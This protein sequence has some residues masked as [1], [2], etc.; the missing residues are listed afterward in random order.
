MQLHTGWGLR[1]FSPGGTDHAGEETY[2]AIRRAILDGT[3][4]PGERIVEQQLAETLG[5]SRTPVR[6]ALLK[7]ERENLVARIGRGMAVRRYSSDEV[8]DI[9]SLRAHL[10]SFAARLAADRITEG[11]LAAL[12]RIQDEMEH[13]PLRPPGEAIRTL[14][15]HNQRFH[16]LVVRCARSAP[17]D[18]CF[19]QV[20]Q[21]PLLYKAYAY[22]DEERRQRSDR[23][24]REL[25]EMLRARRRR[26]R[27]GALAQPSAARRRRAR[28]APRRR[29]SRRV[30]SRPGRRLRRRAVPSRG[31]GPSALSL[32][33]PPRSRWRN[34]ASVIAQH[35]WQRPLGSWYAAV[36]KGRFGVGRVWGLPRW[37][38]VEPVTSGEERSSDL[39]AVEPAAAELAD[40][41]LQGIRVVEFGQLLAGPFVGTLLGDFG[42]EVI[43]IEAPPAGDPMREWGRLRHNGRSMWW[44]ILSR[45]KQSVTLNLRLEQGPAGRSDARPARRRGARELPPGDDGALGT[46]PRRASR[47]STRA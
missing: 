37:R 7:L 14:S 40:G 9:Y 22:F 10:E 46:G 8:R 36:Y 16:A 4:R 18:R 33:P 5:V 29:R 17:L 45:N 28:P 30:L 6:E 19:V 15:R 13:E 1:I 23:D 3:L 26:R 34:G 20:F 11:E 12:A 47:A 24:H 32:Q 31:R 44:S 42:A 21:L 35:G 2:A 39:A 25:I 27:R 41:P 43:K 38:D